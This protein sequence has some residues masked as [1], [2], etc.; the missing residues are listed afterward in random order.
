MCF[1]FFCFKETQLTSPKLSFI[2][3]NLSQCTAFQ[4]EMFIKKVRWGKY[5]M[6]FL[7]SLAGLM[8][9]LSYLLAYL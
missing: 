6:H 3:S 5:G 4:V 8:L 1:L 2:Y 7:L 9:T